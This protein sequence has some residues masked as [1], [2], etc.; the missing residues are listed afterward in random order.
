M[1]ALDTEKKCSVSGAKKYLA[2]I[3]FESG[4]TSKDERSVIFNRHTSTERQNTKNS[5]KSQCMMF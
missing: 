2:A 5:R 3:D 1:P 4:S